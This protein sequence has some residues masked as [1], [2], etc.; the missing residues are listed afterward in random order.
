MSAL[1]QDAP[2]AVR[3]DILEHVGAVGW[4]SSAWTEESLASRKLYPGHTF[5]SK[6]KGWAARLKTT[7]QSMLCM[8]KRVHSTHSDKGGRLD[9][10][11]MEALA[12]RAALLLSSVSEMTSAIPVSQKVKN[13]INKIKTI[14]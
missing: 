13:T 1:P 5:S 11:G 2:T 8:V 3:N 6:G 4:D 9:T 10:A 12:E 14:I 7:E